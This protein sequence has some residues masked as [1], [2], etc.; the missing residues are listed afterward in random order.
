[1]RV[2]DHKDSLTESELSVS[3][4]SCVGGGKLHAGVTPELYDTESEVLVTF[5]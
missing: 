3:G 5:V 4:R 1:M 2:S